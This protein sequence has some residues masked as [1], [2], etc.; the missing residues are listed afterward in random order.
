VFFPAESQLNGSNLYRQL[1]LRLHFKILSYFNT[2]KSLPVELKA[3]NMFYSGMPRERTGLSRHD[4][5]SPLSLLLIIC[6]E[7]LP[8]S[9]G[10]VILNGLKVNVNN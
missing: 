9:V 1:I 6:E 5:R 3:G 2:G 10:N 7:V 4:H 8:V